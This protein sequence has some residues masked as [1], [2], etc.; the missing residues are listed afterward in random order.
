MSA[1]VARPPAARPAGDQ[2]LYAP[3]AAERLAFIRHA[4][5]LGL[6]VEA[7]RDL[8]R[9]SD[10]P[11]RPCADA[12]RIARTHLADVERRVVALKAEL[13]RMVALCEGAG[14]RSAT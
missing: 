11:D 3:A 12:D 13:E 14:S 5:E 2:R 4:R 9:L 10:V 1:V 8:L 7:V 6:P